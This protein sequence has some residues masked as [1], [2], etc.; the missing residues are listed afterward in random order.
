MYAVRTRDI[1]LMIKVSK[2]FG[3]GLSLPCLS[4]CCCAETAIPRQVD[5][6]TFDVDSVLASLTLEEKV[7][8]QTLARCELLW[9]L[10]P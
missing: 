2:A 4:L 7:R 1:F 8:V 5:M 10:I 6:K 3:R 9:R